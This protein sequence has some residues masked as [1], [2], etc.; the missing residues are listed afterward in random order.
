MR[1]FVKIKLSRIGDLTL[2]FTAIGKSCPV[3]DFSSQ[4]CLLVLFAK[5]FRIYSINQN[6]AIINPA[7]NFAI[8]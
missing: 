8:E 2:S 6:H 5:N 1:S 7:I 3:R 4:M